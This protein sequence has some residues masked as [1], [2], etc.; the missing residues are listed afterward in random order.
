M[1]DHIKPTTRLIAEV[2]RQI[3]LSSPGVKFDTKINPDNSFDVLP[4]K[5]NEYYWQISCLAT[6]YCNISHIKKGKEPTVLE[7]FFGLLNPAGCSSADSQNSVLDS[8]WV[9]FDAA[10]QDRNAGDSSISDTD[11]D[12]SETCTDAC[13]DSTPPDSGNSTPLSERMRQSISLRYNPAASESTPSA[14]L[15]SCEFASQPEYYTISGIRPTGSDES[16]SEFSATYFIFSAGAGDSFTI[17]NRNSGNDQTQ[18]IRN[19]TL[20]GNNPV[21][22]TSSNLAITNWDVDCTPALPFGKMEM[23]GKYSRFDAE[24][25]RV[26]YFLRGNHRTETNVDCSIEYRTSETRISGGNQ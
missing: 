25:E 8:G 21:D 3:G 10:V 7:G 1:V 2:V 19:C 16:L 12:V 26:E 14:S 18:D 20:E 24:N 13:S 6:G 22:N 11:F 15:A 5:G 9:Y 23:V 4:S 17:T